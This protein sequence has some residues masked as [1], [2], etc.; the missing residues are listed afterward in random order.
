MRSK[1]KWTLI[2][3]VAFAGLFASTAYTQFA[4][5]GPGDWTTSRLNAQRTAWKKTDTY[6]SVASMEQ[7]GFALQW[8]TR[9]NNPAREMSSLI[10]AATLG[11][12]FNPLSFVTGSSNNIFAIDNDT[13]FVHWQRHIDAPLSQAGSLSCPGGMTAAAS[14][15]TDLVET[16]GPSGPN[17]MTMAR[18]PYQGA[19]GKPGEGVPSHLMSGG[20]FG[21]GS[22]NPFAGRRGGLE[23]ARGRGRGPRGGPRGFAG[24][25]A[26]QYVYAVSSDGVLHR[27]G[28]LSG[29]D[30]GKPLPF[31]PANA[32]VSNLI[33]INNVVYAATEDGCGGA[34]N[35]VWAMLLEG[36]NGTV[37][38]WKTE[39]GSPVGSP[40]FAPDGT[41]YVAIGNGPHS[42]SGY[43]D[44]VV[45]LDPKTLQV[46]D[47]FTQPGA[48]FASTP[49][50]FADGNREIVADA[51]TDGRIFL[52]DAKSLGGN[53]HK[54]PLYDSPAYSSTQTALVPRAL[55][56]W[57]DASGTNW[58][59]EPFA[60]RLPASLASL[61][62]SSGISHGGILA[63]QVVEKDGNPALQPEWVSPDMVTPL[64]PIIVNG[65]VF[66]LSSGEFQPTSGR[67]SVANQIRRSVPAVLYALNGTSGKELWNSGKALASF[68]SSTGLWT[69][70]GQ[71]YVATHDNVVYAFGFPM[72]RYLPGQKSPFLT[73]TA[74]Q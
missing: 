54:T 50:V 27:L 15:S 70:T 12:N 21:P 1:I 52:L 28:L 61:A 29:I 3:T 26:P 65:V 10:G 46:K 35:A 9:L 17:F 59:L 69:T 8:E 18:G 11:A 13:G 5:G 49:M 31:L 62:G 43:S 73:A 72:G 14:R 7:P 64:P 74:Q 71:V 20:M 48:D 53:D 2:L 32:R 51:T 63:F 37:T 6:I 42:A 66:A 60:G 30:T 45:A 56:N 36:D 40:A 44:A 24:A 38:S 23:G 22:R 33:A 55:A 39:G 57:Q 68:V 47:W 67:V 25:F 41:L 19:V 4:N 58:I 16:A 34:P